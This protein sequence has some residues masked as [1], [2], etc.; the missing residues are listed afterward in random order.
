MQRSESIRYVWLSTGL[1][2][3]DLSNS[4]P[5][6]LPL[7]FEATVAV[8]SLVPKNNCLMMFGS[9]GLSKTP[10]RLWLSLYQLTWPPSAAL[11][12]AAFRFAAWMDERA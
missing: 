9:S 1:T 4:S 12:L 5:S 7:L 3:L 6:D 2:L 11:C 8:S 10:W